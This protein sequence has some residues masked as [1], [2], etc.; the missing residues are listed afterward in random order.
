MASRGRDQFTKY[1]SIIL[2]LV[3]MVSIFPKGMRIYFFQT[4]QRTRGK[5]GLL[6]RYI[7]LKSFAKSCGDNVSIHEDVFIKNPDLLVVGSNVSIHPL[8][9][10][11]CAGEVV[12]GND[13]SIAHGVSILSTS[14]NFDRL[15]VPIKDQGIKYKKTILCDN[16]WVG[17]KATI[18]CGNTINY[19]S[20]VGAGAVVTRDVLQGSIVAG[21][22]AKEIDRRDE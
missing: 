3:S 18:L 4:F 11:E 20:I 8:C 17:C 21:V 15:D 19:G 16:V 5:K 9:Y 12:I 6:I 13:V 1:K 2:L 22:P 14:H 10:I 7:F